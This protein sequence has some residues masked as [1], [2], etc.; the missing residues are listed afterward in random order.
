MRKFTNASVLLN[1]IDQR[2][3]D[4]IRPAA[5]LYVLQRESSCLR[6][7]NRVWHR[8]ANAAMPNRQ[9]RVRTTLGRK[10]RGRARNRLS[11]E[12]MGKGSRTITLSSDPCVSE[13]LQ[14]WVRDHGNRGRLPSD[15]GCHPST[16]PYCGSG[17]PPVQSPSHHQDPPLQRH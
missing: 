15:V 12:D 14:G 1:S 4:N 7:R 3:D 6:S 5:P 9:S 13:E 11:D 8:R 2:P 10:G 16:A 17:G